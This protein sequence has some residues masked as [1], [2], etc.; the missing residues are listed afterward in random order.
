LS[1]REVTSSLY[2]EG[3]FRTFFRSAHAKAARSGVCNAMMIGTSKL[4]RDSM[5][6]PN[7]SEDC[8]FA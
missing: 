4:I 6:K 2:Q 8:H 7:V 3:G 1:Y 5:D